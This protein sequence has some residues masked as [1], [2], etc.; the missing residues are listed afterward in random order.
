[1]M[2]AHKTCLFGA[3]AIVLGLTAPLRAEITWP[4][5]NYDPAAEAVPATP[6]DLI[7]PMPCGGAM[8]FQKVNVA[9]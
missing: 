6:A 5:E 4:V 2:R 1:M 9:V 8:A 7:L 3:M